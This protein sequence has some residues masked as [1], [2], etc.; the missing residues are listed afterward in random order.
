MNEIKKKSLKHDLKR[1]LLLIGVYVLTMGNHYFP[2]VIMDLFHLEAQPGTA[3]FICLFIPLVVGYMLYIDDM[4]IDA[5]RQS[6]RDKNSW[7]GI[8]H[9][10]IRLFGWI[11][12]ATILQTV[13]G[14][15]VLKDVEQ[16]LNQQGLEAMFRQDHSMYTILAISVVGPIVEEM[17][18]REVL[19]TQASKYMNIYIAAVISCIAFTAIHCTSLI[20]FVSYLPITVILTIVYFKED[21][22][23]LNTMLFHI[24]YNSFLTSIMFHTL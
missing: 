4:G 1:A 24:M 21:R 16:S 9:L 6:E 8:I 19:I 14:M 11:I 13:L 18:F 22:N 23:V 15:T 2:K 17:I 10:V 3:M 7:S 5:K 20:E 12:V